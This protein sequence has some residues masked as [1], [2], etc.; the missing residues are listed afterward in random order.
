M[1]LNCVQTIP[2]S[3]WWC[4]TFKQVCKNVIGD[5]VKAGDKVS[6]ELEIDN[7]SIKTGPYYYATKAIVGKPAQLKQLATFREKS[8]DTHSF[9]KGRE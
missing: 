1:I 6:V 8:Q 9:S 3:R 4:T 7:E 5:N 2:C